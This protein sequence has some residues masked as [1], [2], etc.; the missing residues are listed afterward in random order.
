MVC[1][2]SVDHDSVPVSVCVCV[3]VCVHLFMYPSSPQASSKLIRATIHAGLVCQTIASVKVVPGR[4]SELTRKDITCK[5]HYAVN[6]ECV[7]VC[8]CVCVLRCARH[9]YV[10]D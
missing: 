8:V 2:F 9:H 4:E 7:C 5:I 10:C 3:C 6:G 1:N